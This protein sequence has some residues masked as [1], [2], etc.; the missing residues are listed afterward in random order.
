MEWHCQFS[1]LA[2]VT[3]AVYDFAH[4]HSHGKI[5]SNNL[6]PDMQPLWTENDVIPHRFGGAAFYRMEKVERYTINHKKGT[7]KV[8]DAHKQNLKGLEIIRK[9]R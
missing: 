4:I 9:M 6:A 8:T 2:S 5:L 7:M 3:E 1:V